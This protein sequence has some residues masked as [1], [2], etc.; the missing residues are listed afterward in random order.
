MAH[1]SKRVFSISNLTLKIVKSFST[2]CAV[3][4]IENKSM[5]SLNAPTR[6]MTEIA[7]PTASIVSLTWPTNEDVPEGSRNGGLSSRIYDLMGVQLED[8]MMSKYGLLLT[9]KLCTRFFSGKRAETVLM[10]LESEVC[11][12]E[13]G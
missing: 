7:K 10:S 5:Q 6:E 2:D 1:C 3:E 13:A 9:R 4:I 11:I 12:T 8:V